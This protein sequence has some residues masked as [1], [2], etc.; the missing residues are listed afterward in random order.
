MYVQYESTGTKV[1][2]GHSIRVPVPKYLY[3][4]YLSTV[5]TV[6][7]YCDKLSKGVTQS[8]RSVTNCQTLWHRVTI[9]LRISN[10]IRKSRLKT[11]H[12]VLTVTK[13]QRSVTRSQRFD[14]ES[15]GFDKLSQPVLEHL[16]YILCQLTARHCTYRTNERWHRVTVRM[17]LQETRRVYVHKVLR[18][19]DFGGLTFG[20]PL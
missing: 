2:S 14:T 13:S 17:P 12:N 11:W 6:Q 19:F 15:Q 3:V 5:R 10:I 18:Y 4:Q 8:Q 16:F 20:T 9:P 7:K 1:L